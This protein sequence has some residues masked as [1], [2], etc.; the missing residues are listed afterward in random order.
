MY[1]CDIDQYIIFRENFHMQ[2]HYHH[3]K[4]CSSVSLN[5]LQESSHSTGVQL[6]QSVLLCITIS[7]HQTVAAAQLPP[8]TPPSLVLMYQLM[9]VCVCLL[10]RLLSVKESLG[11]LALVYQLTFFKKKVSSY[12]HD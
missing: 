4:R 11:N 12:I 5:L 3:Q 9:M 10:C 1:V 7:Y 2:I 8:I 6:P